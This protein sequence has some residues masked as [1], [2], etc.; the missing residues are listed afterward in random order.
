MAN[1]QKYVNSKN[2]EKF[3]TT[4]FTNY[5]KIEKCRYLTE[6]SITINGIQVLLQNLQ[7]LSNEILRCNVNIE[8]Y[9]TQMSIEAVRN[10]LQDAVNN[11]NVKKVTFFEEKVERMTVQVKQG[12]RLEQIFLQSG[13]HIIEHDTSDE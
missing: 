7:T 6:L 13:A 4:F 12:E 11:I 5:P 9:A 1:L 3:L 10:Y 8:N 2:L